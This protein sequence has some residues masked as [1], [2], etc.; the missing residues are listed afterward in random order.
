MRDREVAKVDVRWQTRTRRT[1]ELAPLRVSEQAR[2][3]HA[4]QLAGVPV[5]VSLGIGWSDVR[6][7]SQRLNE[8]TDSLDADAEAQI[9]F[10]DPETIEAQAKIEEKKGVLTGGPTV[11]AELR[12]VAKVL[13]ARA[14][15]RGPEAT[16]RDLEWSSRWVDFFGRWKLWY[17]E[18][19]GPSAL[20]PSGSVSWEKNQAFDSELRQFVALFGALKGTKV[21]RPLP[22]SIESP[23]GKK[24]DEPKGIETTIANTV[25]TAAKVVAGGIVVVGGLYVLGSMLK[26]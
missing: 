22:E 26:T 23:T 15:A 9:V 11:A 25:S 16:A 14:A 20:A 4:M 10:V 18:V 6:A 1:R 2:P 17:S 24:A 21:T 7:Y 19:M 3:R 5:N 13:R 8:Y 12:K